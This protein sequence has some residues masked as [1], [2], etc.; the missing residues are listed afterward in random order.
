MKPGGNGVQEVKEEGG[1]YISGSGLAGSKI[2]NETPPPNLTS[3]PLA[4]AILRRLMEYPV[5]G[6]CHSNEVPVGLK[7]FPICEK[8]KV[9][10]SRGGRN[11]EEAFG[12]IQKKIMRNLYERG[13]ESG[14]LRGGKNI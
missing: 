3:S 8:R 12:A 13:G 2:P 1:V 5:E 14:N 4:H 7:G 11:A 6:Q 9:A 10:G